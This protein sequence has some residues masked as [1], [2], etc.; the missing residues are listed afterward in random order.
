MNLNTAKKISA[1]GHESR[2]RDRVIY[3]AHKKAIRN[4]M[5]AVDRCD[6]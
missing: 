1:D 4:R 5:A 6:A 3:R 2:P